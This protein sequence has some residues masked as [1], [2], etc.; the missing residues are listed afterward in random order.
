M[1]GAMFMRKR[2]KPELERSV[3]STLWALGHMSAILQCLWTHGAF[4]LL[5]CEPNTAA[6]NW[7]LLE[8]NLKRRRLHGILSTHTSVFAPVFHT[9][10][11]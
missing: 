4:F 8:G 3:E 2:K 7:E 1:V 10:S 9:F 6:K 11:L 5:N